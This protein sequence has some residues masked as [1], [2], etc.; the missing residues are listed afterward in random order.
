MNSLQTF[1]TDLENRAYKN[2]DAHNIIKNLTTKL[3]PEE[4]KKDLFAEEVEHST[5]NH[6]KDVED[7]G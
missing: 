1:S 2:T 3:N 6:N 7:N 5:V 4:D